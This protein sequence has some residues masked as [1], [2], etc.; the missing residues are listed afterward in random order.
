MNFESHFYSRIKMSI[1]S[2]ASEASLLS[3]SNER[4]SITE[5]M[6]ALPLNANFPE[7]ALKMAIAS[8]HKNPERLKMRQGAFIYRWGGF[9][10]TLNE[11]GGFEAFLDTRAD[12][13]K[14]VELFKRLERVRTVA[15]VKEIIYTLD[16]ADVDYLNSSLLDQLQEVCKEK[17][18][19]E[20]AYDKR[21]ME[22][23]LFLSDKRD[24]VYQILVFAI[25]CHN[26]SLVRFALGCGADIHYQDEFALQ[27][28]VLF[29][30]AP[31]TEL[32]IA[33]G[34]DLH[35]VDDLMLRMACTKGYV[36]VVKILL[37]YG[38][39]VHIR[40]DDPLLTACVHGYLAI[41][42]LLVKYGANVNVISTL[43]DSSAPLRVARAYNRIDIANFL[44]SKGA[45]EYL[46]E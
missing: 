31:I 14:Y 1:P 33:Q 18:Y 19:I 17:E 25:R 21:Y 23:L 38:A 39:N 26:V 6:D 12:V 15:E 30:T 35:V 27:T 34:A 2:V 22:C 46:E 3:L 37:K 5:R 16:Q 10:Q 43:G 4:N 36:E 11:L 45:I 24:A 42:K 7:E 20:L 40:N 41:V 44:L 8:K 13:K 28:A 9:L 32:L 29:N